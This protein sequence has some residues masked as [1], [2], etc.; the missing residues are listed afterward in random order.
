MSEQADWLW[1]EVKKKKLKQY[2][3]PGIGFITVKLLQEVGKTQHK[4]KHKFILSI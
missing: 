1:H 3:S 2:R 4:N